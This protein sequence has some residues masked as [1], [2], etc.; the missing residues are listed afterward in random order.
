MKRLLETVRFRS[1]SRAAE[2]A[3]RLTLALSPAVQTGI[4]SLLAASPDPDSALHMIT[5]L[6]EEKP[7]AFDR[8]TS[9]VAGLTF[10]VA[11][12][13]YSHFLSQDVLKR[14]D[15]LEDLTKSDDTDRVLSAEEYERKLETLLDE[16]EF[17]DPKAS[18]APSPLTLSLFRRR[19]LLRILIRDVQGFCTLPETTE[20]LS[21]L[22]D[23]I[24]AVACRRLRADLAGRYGQPRSSEP[25]AE[26]CGFAVL[27]LGKHGGR[28]LN[29]S[30]DID[31]MFLYGGSGE[32]DGPARIANQE[33]FK[34]LANKCVELLSTYTEEGRCYR[35]DLRLRPEGRTGEIALSLEAARNYYQNRARDWELQMLIKARVSAGDRRLGQSLLEFLEPKIYSTTLDFSAVESMSATR[36]RISEKL[37]ARKGWQAGF[38]IKLARGGIR[39]IEFLVQCLQ[40]LHGGREPWVR[41]GGSMLALF[42]LRDKDL[43]SGKEYSKLASAY[44]FLRN[45]EHRLQFA[46]DR[47]THTLPSDSEELSVLARKMPADEHG[48]LVSGDTL[49]GQVNRHLE[50]VQ[51]LYA[52]IVHAQ[53]PMYYSL[54]PTGDSGERAREEEPVYPAD[55]SAS[56]VM[57]SLDLRAPKLAG[58][59]LQSDLRRGR[60]RFEHF[61]ELILTRTEF[62]GWLD[63][64][65]ILA[66]RTTD[67]FERS[68]YFAEQLIR[69]P[70]LLG[71]LRS[72]ESDSSAP[73]ALQGD[74]IDELRL[75][76]LRRMFQIQSRSI[77]LGAPIFTTLEET[78]DLADAIIH[79]A[80]RLAV[81]QV[82]RSRPPQSAGY[83][84]AS[85]MMVVSLGRL[86]MR[87]FD[88]GSDADLVFVLPDADA[89]ELPFWTHVAERTIELITSYTGQGV[90]FAVD[91]RLRPNGR[92]GAL[93]QLES[94]YLSYFAKSAEAWEGITYLKSRSV[95]GD[96]ERATMF[97]ENLQ[98]VDWRHYGQSGRSRGQLMQMRLRLEKEQGGS[99]PLKAGRG[100]YYDIDFALM[101]LRLKGAGI[102][103]KVLNTPARIDVIEKMGHLERSDASF[104]RD[105]ATFYRAVDHGLRVGTGHTEG[106][107]PVAPAELENLTELVRRWTPDHLQDQP[108]DIEL[109][110]IQSGTREFFNRLFSV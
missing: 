25:G 60:K 95:A 21:N 72:I 96:A 90:M 67:L 5:R 78:S 83:A 69:S 45:L 16:E 85:Q 7:E 108:L 57:R 39:D 105:A 91:T 29:Y 46:D 54:T 63:E 106:D 66:Q 49:L 107:L 50:E 38:D 35:V 15:W 24:L 89:A 68:H 4:R 103:F 101:Y 102:F 99:N 81:D 87:E 18:G 80:Y 79:A 8:L 47:Q 71:E 20:E 44:Q 92:E 30:S 14:P 109:A 32:T 36:L 42:R 86:G 65:P 73:V 59:L 3:A 56:N 76:F 77:C 61:L 2:N 104:L 17:L 6:K 33:F 75:F 9:S 74:G 62:L 19:Q 31:L 22:A 52:R 98:G 48:G 97:L 12:P 82:S 94:S 64:D 43:L 34:K 26:E 41:Q 55:G 23:A 1:P 11:V 88:L 13:S 58:S 10:L 51:E 40:R 37:A 70:E 93:V 110:Q 28:E 27:S 84:A 100:G 53:Q